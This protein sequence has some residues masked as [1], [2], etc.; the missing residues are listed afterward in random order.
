MSKLH[1]HSRI[2]TW[3]AVVQW[4]FF[5]WVVVIGIRFGAFVRHFETGGTTPLVSRPPGV[6]GFLPIG[7]WPARSSGS[8]RGPSTRPSGGPGHL[9]TVVA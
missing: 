4:G 9:L 8:P 2:P 5:A 1:L 7:P 3:R 6:E